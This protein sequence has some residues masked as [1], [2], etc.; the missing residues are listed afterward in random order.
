M[1]LVRLL[2]QGLYL[3]FTYRV[4][5]SIEWVLLAKQ[6]RPSTLPSLGMD[7]SCR[8]SCG[9]SSLTDGRTTLAL[10]VQRKVTSA[11]RRRT[12]ATLLSVWPLSLFPPHSQSCLTPYE[13]EHIFPSE[14]GHDHKR[15]QISF[16]FK[17]CQGLNDSY[18]SHMS[19]WSMQ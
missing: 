13:N 11:E 8:F 1:S 4:C 12:M 6:I 5:P 3:Q 7:C 10:S 14:R 15:E 17:Q 18:F 19:V 2:F 16:P 9:G